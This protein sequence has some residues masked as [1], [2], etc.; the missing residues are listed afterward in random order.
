MLSPYLER[1]YLCNE[2]LFYAKYE[3][4]QADYLATINKPYYNY[5]LS[6]KESLLKRNQRMLLI[7]GTSGA[8]YLFVF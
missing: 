6:L 2:V 4:E 1:H 3:L 5:L 8:F 7:H